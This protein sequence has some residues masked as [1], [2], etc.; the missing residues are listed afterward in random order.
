MAAPA[1]PPRF[2]ATPSKIDASKAKVVPGVVAVVEYPGSGHRFAGVAVLAKNTWAARRGRDGLHVEWDE[3]KAFRLGSAEIFAQYRDLAGKPG[4]VAC[5]EGDA[6]KA[7]ELAAKRID[8]D[9]ELPYLA[10]ASAFKEGADRQ[11][12]S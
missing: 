5:N 8:A 11:P 2:G 7:L 9:F 6:G 4:K 10:H 1:H 12:G 3:S